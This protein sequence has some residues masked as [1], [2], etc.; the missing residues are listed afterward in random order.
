MKKILLFT[1][2]GIALG[3]T[4]S[5]TVQLY[6]SPKKKPLKI[7]YNRL[8]MAPTWILPEDFTAKK[9][10]ADQG[11][12]E[13]LRDADLISVSLADKDGE[14]AFG[15]YRFSKTEIFLNKEDLPLVKEVLLSPTCYRGVSA[16]EFS[17]GALF[18]IKNKGKE[19]HILICLSCSDLAIG[20]PNTDQTYPVIGLS[21]V[22]IDSI[23]YFLLKAF[24]DNEKFQRAATS[25]GY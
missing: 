6:H 5:I 16:C 10:Y 22:G 4:G 15:S 13:Q 1:I 23:L 17:P 12:Y 8:S 9:M 7:D 24:P 14:I 25:K 11:I 2:L 19:S 3:I 18:R 20:K 21:K